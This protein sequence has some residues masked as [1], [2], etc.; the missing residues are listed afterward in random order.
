MALETE[1]DYQRE[2]DDL[3]KKYEVIYNTA[4]KQI[5]KYSQQISDIKA[6][7]NEEVKTIAS[8]MNKIE[9]D[10]KREL[11][12]LDKKILK[13]E[14]EA[15]EKGFKIKRSAE[16]D[17]ELRALETQD[18]YQDKIDDLLKEVEDLYDEGTDKGFKLKREEEMNQEE[19]ALET[20]K[21]YQKEYDRLQREWDNLREDCNKL[22]KISDKARAEFNKASGE[23]M[24]KVNELR[25]IQ[26]KRDAIYNQARDKGFKLKRGEELSFEER[27]N[28]IISDLTN[29]EER[30]NDVLASLEERALETEK[31]YQK[32]YDKINAQWKE[33]I[34]IE[35]TLRKSMKSKIIKIQNE[36]DDQVTE[37]K[38]KAAKLFKEKQ[39]IW[40]D[41]KKK[42]FDLRD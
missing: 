11:G 34:D 40:M 18:D 25:K 32:A 3:V 36:L 26:T 28:S 1:K 12:E 37:A 16:L 27:K 4:V 10:M 35:E 22:E 39:Q 33:Q 2:I 21:D 5:S 23:Y 24:K 14:K 31:D 19:R 38:N 30:K 7:A 15:K 42:G 20:E 13:L 9:D 41:A 8:K 17:F 29:L 6:D